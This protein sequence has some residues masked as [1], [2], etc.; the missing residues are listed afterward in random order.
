M[1]TALVMIK[2][3]TGKEK[4]VFEKVKKISEVKEAELLL[5]LYDVYAKV[6]CRQSDQ[7]VEIILTKIRSIPGVLGTKTLPAIESHHKP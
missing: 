6:V 3:A 5:G 2:T 7:L 1:A 4:E